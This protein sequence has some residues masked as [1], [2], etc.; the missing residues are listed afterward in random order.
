MEGTS[1]PNKMGIQFMALPKRTRYLGNEQESVDERTSSP[2]KHEIDLP[3][4]TVRK[5]KKISPM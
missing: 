4:A 3:N 2:Q 5:T 1:I